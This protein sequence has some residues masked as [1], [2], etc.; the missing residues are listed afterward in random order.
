MFYLYYFYK[1]KQNTSRTDIKNYDEKTY[2]YVPTYGDES[3]IYH[4]HRIS[5]VLLFYSNTPKSMLVDYAIIEMGC[6]GGYLYAAPRAK[7]MTVNGISTFLLHVAQCISLCQTNIVTAKLISEA[8]LKPFYSRI[9][10]KVIK[11]FATSP[12]FE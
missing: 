11:D 12:N 3:T 9:G 6:F 1:P 7:T 8:L 5:V 2:K 4:C 10:F